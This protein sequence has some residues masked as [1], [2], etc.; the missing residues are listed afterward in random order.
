MV[1]RG[2]P[3][4]RIVGGRVEQRGPHIRRRV[5]DGGNP[6]Q[7]FFTLLVFLDLI[8][9]QHGIGGSTIALTEDVNPQDFSGLGVELEQIDVA[10]SLELP[11]DLERRCNLLGLLGGVVRFSF[12]RDGSRGEEDR[13]RIRRPGRTRLCGPV[14]RLTADGR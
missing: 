7:R 12:E 5:I 4:L 6:R 14:P 3:E 13:D 2:E 10:A 11:G 1:S 8:D 9:D